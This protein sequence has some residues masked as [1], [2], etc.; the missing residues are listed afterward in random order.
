M[1]IVS[2]PDCKDSVF[3]SVIVFRS[4][5]ASRYISVCDLS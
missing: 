3:L 5:V 4:L 2:P 1:V